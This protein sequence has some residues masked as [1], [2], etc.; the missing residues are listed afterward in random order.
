MW[1]LTKSVWQAQARYWMKIKWTRYGTAHCT[2]KKENNSSP[3]FLQII[4]DS[5]HP[6]EKSRVIRRTGNVFKLIRHISLYTQI[7]VYKPMKLKI[8]WK[9][10]R[11][12]NHISLSARPALWVPVIIFSNND[13]LFDKNTTKLQNVPTNTLF[14]LS[15]LAQPW[16]NS[17]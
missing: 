16:W 11:Q 6:G 17:S 13:N 15:E 2:H 7:Y 1:K 14:N 12:G 4:K 3:E 5:S 8:F 10:L 9:I